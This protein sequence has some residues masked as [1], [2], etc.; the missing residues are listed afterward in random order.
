MRADTYSMQGL[1]TLYGYLW[2]WDEHI[3]LDVVAICWDWTEY[4]DE[5]SLLSE[6]TEYD[7]LDD[8]ERQTTVLR[9]SHGQLIVRAFPY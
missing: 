9:T 4:A 7:C 2:D 1:E 3:E 8:I 5:A 6:F